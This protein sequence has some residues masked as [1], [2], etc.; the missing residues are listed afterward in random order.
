MSKRK[1]KASEEREEPEVDDGQ[2]TFAITVAWSESRIEVEG[3]RFGSVGV[4]YGA[5]P[6][7]RFT[8]IPTGLCFA[9]IEA[10][11][12]YILRAARIVNAD[13]DLTSED[14]RETGARLKAWVNLGRPLSIKEVGEKLLAVAEVPPD[15]AVRAHDGEPR[16]T[17]TK[18]RRRKKP[19]PST[20]AAESKPKKAA[21]KPG[22]K[23]GAA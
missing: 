9:R 2:E 7:A 5:S 19:T 20:S 11:H 12:G 17:P 13:V 4:H 23:E 6:E 22:R 18:T 14:V 1:K 8:H 3:W 10:P 16:Y 21:R 15:V